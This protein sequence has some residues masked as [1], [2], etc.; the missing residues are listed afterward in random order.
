MLNH[1]FLKPHPIFQVM[2]NGTKNRIKTPDFKNG[3]AKNRGR[4]EVVKLLLDLSFT[5]K[6]PAKAMQNMC[7]RSMKVLN[8]SYLTTCRNVHILASAIYLNIEPVVKNT[9]CC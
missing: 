5:D 2:K 4:C 3:H 7:V 9:C 6:L 8:L 1:V